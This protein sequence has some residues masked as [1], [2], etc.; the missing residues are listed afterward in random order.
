M[1]PLFAVGGDERPVAAAAAAPV[2][3]WRP[4][5]ATAEAPLRRPMI[6]RVAVGCGGPAAGAAAVIL[7]AASAGVEDRA[8]GALNITGWTVPARLM[9]PAGPARPGRTST[10][11]PIGTRCVALHMASSSFFVSSFLSSLAPSYTISY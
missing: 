6:C 4:E 3:G 9:A 10:D 2:A 1:R 11:V 7:T 8:D 5:H